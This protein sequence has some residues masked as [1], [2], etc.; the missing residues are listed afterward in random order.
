[1]SKKTV[2]DTV[3][4]VGVGLIGGSIGQALRKRKLARQVLGVGRRP[5][6]LRK[7]LACKAIDQGIRD[8]DSAVGDADLVVVCTPLA[9]ICETVQAVRRSCRADTLITDVGSTKASIVHGVESAA[10][11]SR[12]SS[13]GR[14]IGSH[15]IAGSE[16]SGVEF[17]DPALFDGR[18]TIV[19][20]PSAPAVLAAH[21]ECLERVCNFWRSLGSRLTLMTPEAHDEVMAATSHLPHLVASALAGATPSDLR[22]F[23][24]PGWRDTTRIAAADSSLWTEILTD[25]SRY[26]LRAL[27]QLLKRLNAFRSAIGKLSPDDLHRLLHEGKT[28]RDALGN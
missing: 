14:F 23:V 1:M 27:D 12:S 13:L 21:E 9:K 8:L 5:A 20:P 10:G 25:N 19:T 3:V 7:A 24:G 26:T 11:K 18:M 4:I 15:P 22:E 6:S 28:S 2:W 16:K 17:A